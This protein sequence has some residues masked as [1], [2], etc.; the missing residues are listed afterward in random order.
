MFTEK[1]EYDFVFTC[2]TNFLEVRGTESVEKIFC[3]QKV[4]HSKLQMR[5]REY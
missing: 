4:P 2:S 3:T 5:I 1:V